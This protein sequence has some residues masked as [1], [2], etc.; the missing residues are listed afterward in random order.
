[1]EPDDYGLVMPGPLSG[2]HVVEACQMVAGPWAGTICADLGADV[3]KIENPAGGDRFRYAGHRVGNI[4]AAWAGVNRGKRSVVLDLQHVEAVDA[5]KRIVATADVFI[6]NF[7]PGVAERLGIGEPALRAVNADLIY[8]SVSGFGDSGPYVDQKTYDY[9]IQ[10]LSGM[11]ALQTDPTT[12]EP[13]LIRNLVID[14]ITAMAAAQAIIAALLARERGAG[15]Q[16][17]QLSM[18]DVALGFVWPDG[19]MQHT[20]LATD[21]RVRPG[22]HLADNYMVRKTADGFI[23]LSATSNSQFP[24]LCSALDKPDWLVDERF[25]TLAARE[26]NADEINMLIADALCMVPGV[27]L[28]A[29]LQ[30]HDVPCALVAAIDSV[31]LDPQVQ[32]NEILVEHERPWLGVVREPLPA[33]HYSATPTSFGRHA[34]ALDEHT[35]EVLSEV[36]F[37]S[38]EL[39]R[40]RQ[41]GIIGRRLQ[42]QSQQQ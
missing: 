5:L 6:Q 21:G 31:H 14:K 35:D 25:A 22:P 32:H 30:A 39:S 28:V 8:V 9:V 7:R 40:L 36:G 16:H 20:L 1:M 17:V 19:M 11:A 3:T 37:A 18:L 23:A 26:A 34:P 13:A 12:G 4:G 10:A 27:E 42:Q 29:V 15:G 33:A 2:F 24:G 41:I 38:D